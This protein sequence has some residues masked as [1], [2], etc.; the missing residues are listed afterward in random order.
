MNSKHIRDTMD[1][2]FEELMEMSRDDLMRELVLNG[3]GDIAAILR[4]TGALKA[5]EMEATAIY[6]E[7][8]L[9]Q[10]L[11]SPDYKSELSLDLSGIVQ[12]IQHPQRA[13]NNE[14]TARDPLSRVEVALYGQ[15]SATY[16]TG[17]NKELQWAA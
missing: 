16:M 6:G 3:D 8:A 5:R 17:F 12:P 2:V 10:P 11:T 4:Y 1:S 9:T 15:G 13:A 14:Y 7:I